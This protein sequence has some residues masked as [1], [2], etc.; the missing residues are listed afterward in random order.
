MA[1]GVIGYQHAHGSASLTKVHCVQ[2]YGNNTI[3]GV[4]REMQHKAVAVSN[5]STA[6]SGLQ[7]PSVLDGDEVIRHCRQLGGT[8]YLVTDEEV[9]FWQKE[10]AR[11]EGIF[12]EPA[13]AVALAGLASA[14]RNNEIGEKDNVVCLITGSGF[15]DMNAV[16][17]NFQLPE[18]SIIEQGT[19][20]NH[21]LTSL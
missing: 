10:L 12:S 5:A 2:P 1:K 18:I 20:L 11:K 7:V 16:D 19:Q 15:K 13:G 8:G 17:N 6:I 9:F 14:S 3:A 4:L 21:E